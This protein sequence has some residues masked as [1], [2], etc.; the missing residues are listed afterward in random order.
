MITRGFNLVMA[1]FCIALGI[2]IV[3]AGSKGGGGFI[4]IVG[5]LLIG[6]GCYGLYRYVFMR[7]K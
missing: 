5:V 3:A 2:G 6:Y 7:T 4:S 1:L